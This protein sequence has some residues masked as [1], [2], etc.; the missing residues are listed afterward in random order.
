MKLGYFTLTDNPADYG[1]LQRDP[2]QYLLDVMDEAVLAEELGFHS[3]WLPEH[4]FGLFGCLPTPALYLANLAARTRRIK[5]APGTVVLP[6]NHPL[7]IAEEY[8]SL[9]LLSNGRAILSVGRGYDHRE[10]AG[11]G[12]PFAESRERFDEGL[13]LVRK[14]LSEEAITWDGPHY[15]LETPITILPRPVQRPHPPIYVACFSRPT[16]ELAARGGYHGLFAPFAASM[17]FGSL[18]NAV[19]EFRMLAAQADHPRPRVMCSYF[20]VLAD[21]AAE[22]LRGKERLLRYLLGAAP[23]L[24]DPQVPPPPHMAYMADVVKQLHALRPEQLGERSVIAGSA[25]ECVAALK[26]I[27]EAGIDE[28][29][30]YLHFGGLEHA[31][32]VRLMERCA[33]EILPH[34]EPAAVAAGA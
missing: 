16:V 20:L 6:C 9:D 26:R 34:F 15:R 1:S 21:D 4:H 14:A 2:N 29:I 13:A 17:V 19:A 27:E 18:A 24:L 31:A 12:V 23:A 3:V 7:R 28:V 5:L 30:L 32:T 10:Y 8:A 11:F 25:E 22:V 33:R